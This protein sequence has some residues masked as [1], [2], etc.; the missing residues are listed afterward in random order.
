MTYK[1]N[2]D[3]EGLGPNEE[4]VILDD[5]SRIAVSCVVRRMTHS[6]DQ[7]YHGKARHIG[8]DGI[9]LMDA[10]GQHII[11]EHQHTA[12]SQQIA[13]HGDLALRKEVMLLVM[14]EEATMVEEFPVLPVEDR[15]RENSSIRRA[16]ASAAA[17]HLKVEHVL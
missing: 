4:A 7:V 5:G 11:T 17:T 9:T 1:I 15:L 14:G 10:H 13:L 8:E 3:Q 2:H 16:I 6:N 12:T